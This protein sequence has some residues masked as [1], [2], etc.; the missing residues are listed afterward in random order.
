MALPTRQ[1]VVVKFTDLGHVRWR[2]EFERD[3]DGQIYGALY[4][5]DSNRATYIRELDKEE[6]DQL[7]EFF[8]G[9]RS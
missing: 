1:Q 8:S 5:G 9:G 4:W 6:T 7:I 3:E 2:L